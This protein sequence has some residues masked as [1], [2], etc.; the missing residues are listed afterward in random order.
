MRI[1]D[2]S[3]DVC[4]SDLV[5]HAKAA[6][7]I[8]HAYV[9]RLK[10]STDTGPGAI[11]IAIQLQQRIAAAVLGQIHPTRRIEITLCQ[12]RHRAALL[13]A[14]GKAGLQLV[15]QYPI[16]FLVAGNLRPGHG[17]GAAG[18]TLDADPEELAGIALY[19]RL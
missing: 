16:E 8:V 13:G 14:L 2:W 17:G 5:I 3:S 18:W 9:R 4:S 1:S 19:T 11:E 15:E 10:G 7:Q 12:Q 6:V